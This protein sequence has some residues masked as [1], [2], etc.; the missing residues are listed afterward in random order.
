MSHYR[1]GWAW[2]W[3]YRVVVQWV[4]WVQFIH[5]IAPRILEHQSNGSSIII[6]QR[7]FNARPSPSF[8]HRPSTVYRAVDERRAAVCYIISWG[9]VI[10]RQISDRSW[11]MSRSHERCGSSRHFRPFCTFCTVIINNRRSITG[12]SEHRDHEPTIWPFWPANLMS[13]WFYESLPHH[14]TFAQT[15]RLLSSWD[16]ATDMR[17]HENTDH[18]DEQQMR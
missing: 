3:C 6:H 2:T 1:P 15:I 10:V 11:A 14:Y 18:Q 7:S 12:Q 4:Q 16:H 13:D 8:H 5:I 9:S 17:Q